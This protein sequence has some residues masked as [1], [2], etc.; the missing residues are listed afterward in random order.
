MAE[1]AKIDKPEIVRAIRDLLVEQLRIL[2]EIGEA[3]AAIELDSAI[4]I[5]GKRLGDPSD[6]EAADRLHRRYF[7]N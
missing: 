4:G 5:L 1:A 3:E 2:D 6:S 7:S